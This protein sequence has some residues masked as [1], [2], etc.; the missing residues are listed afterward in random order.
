MWGFFFFPYP[1]LS[2]KFVGNG[3]TTNKDKMHYREKSEVYLSP[4]RPEQKNLNQSTYYLHFVLIYSVLYFISIY[5][6]FCSGIQWVT[7]VPDWEEI[8]SL[9][10]KWRIEFSAGKIAILTNWKSEITSHKCRE[11][12]LVPHLEQKPHKVRENCYTA[13]KWAV[14]NICIPPEVPQ[15]KCR[16]V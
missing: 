15:L 3:T 12:V 10:I 14:E 13:Y 16:R 4:L 1:A 11:A 2:S 9:Q 8:N 7:T 6:N 5:P